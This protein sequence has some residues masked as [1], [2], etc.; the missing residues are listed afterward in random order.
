MTR[1]F[2]LPAAM[3]FAL[4]LFAGRAAATDAGPFEPARLRG[5]TAYV[6]VAAAPLLRGGEERRRDH[7]GRILARATALFAFDA[8]RLDGVAFAFSGSLSPEEW[9]VVLS[10]DGLGA[11]DLAALFA[12]MFPDPPTP[13]PDGTGRLHLAVRP[14]TLSAAA[15][16]G[17]LL[18]AAEERAARFIDGPESPAGALPEHGACT[19]P[20][21]GARPELLLFAMGGTWL[22]AAVAPLIDGTG[23]VAETRAFAAGLTG[24]ILTLVFALR[25]GDHGGRLAAALPRGGEP[26]SAAPALA[27]LAFEGLATRENALHARYRLDGASSE[28]LRAAVVRLLYERMPDDARSLDEALR[29]IALRRAVR[30]A[31]LG[32]TAD[33]APAAPP[34]LDGCPAGGK[35]LDWTTSAEP[36]VECTRHAPFPEGFIAD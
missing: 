16:P 7:A 18:F 24:D 14:G 8:A 30:L 6:R 34:R 31:R 17:E 13:R 21:A 5:V 25:P 23:V 2:L 20:F 28:A 15:A 36:R 35:L 32:T 1:R 26:P 12:R 4:L 27:R 33:G 11:T 9:A 10:G 22:H 19:G 29:C 3:A